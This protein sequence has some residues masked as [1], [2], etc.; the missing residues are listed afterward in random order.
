MGSSFDLGGIYLAGIFTFFSPCVL[1]VIPL[2]M[3]SL[4]GTSLKK[5]SGLK[6]RLSLLARSFAFSLGFVLVFSIL[7]IG[8]S[9]L[10]T[11]LLTHKALVKL[12]GGIFILLFSLKFLGVIDVPL[13]ENNFGLNS[14]SL[15][16]STPFELVNSFLMGVVFSLNWTSCSGP[17]LS[18]VLSYTASRAS[19]MLKGALY[20]STF[21]FGFS[22]PL[23][24]A[25]LF[26]SY[27]LTFFR[28]INKYLKYM[29]FVL[30]IVLLFTSVVLLYDL[31]EKPWSRSDLL[32][33]QECKSGGNLP[34]L[35]EFYSK[36]CHICKQIQ[37]T[38]SQFM[39]ECNGKKLKII[40]IDV[41]Q[42]ENKYLRKRFNLIG[43]P[44]FVFLDENQ[45]EVAR[46]IGKQTLDSLKNM[47]S[48]LVGDTC[49]AI[50]NFN[51]NDKTFYTNTNT[52]DFTEENI[53][54][55]QTE[56]INDQMN[57]NDEQNSEDSE[58]CTFNQDDSL[59]CNNDHK[60][61]L[62]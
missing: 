53:D 21:G 33:Q 18:S 58:M 49:T 59:S 46:L 5:V 31:I 43:L 55:D 61:E 44:T 51:T 56:D 9:A 45:H 42:K 11:F 28:K 38:V 30:G 16:S 17:V 37:P 41:S 29:K 35:I 14:H 4:A 52:N 36:N 50:G 23:L 57:N 25:S 15:D 39:D 12:V 24:F 47:A 8:V 48:I 6:S 2:W 10:G 54:S 60:K 20:L 13:L 34:L 3:S 27:V 40:Q 22:T 19:S 1:P 26:A 32:D 7:G 62:Y